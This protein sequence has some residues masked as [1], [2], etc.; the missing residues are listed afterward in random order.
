MTK[1]REFKALVRERMTKTGERYAAARAQLLSQSTAAS[2]TGSARDRFPG[3]LPGYDQFGGV[4]N[5]TAPV[6]NVLGFAGLR[7][8]ATGQPFTEAVV[9]GLCGGPGF[10]Y[11]VFEYKGWPPLLSIALQSRSMPDAFLGQGLARLGV[12]A[13][14]HETGSAVAARKTLE[15]VL[16]AGKPAPCATG[17]RTVAVVGQAGGPGA[18]WWVDGR[19]PVPT[20]LTAEML[21]RLRGGYKATKNRLT[22]LDGPDTAADPTARLREAVAQTAQAYLDPPVPKAFQGNCGFAGL[23]KWQRLLTDP[24]DAKGWRTLFAEGPRACAGLTRAYEWI[25]CFVAPGAGRPFYASFLDVAAEVLSAPA[26]RT[27]AGAFREAGA[28]WSSLADQ[29]ATTED[30][31]VRRVCDAADA[32]LEALDLEGDCRTAENPIDV[33]QKRRDASADSTLTKAAAE[34][35]Y[36]DMARQLGR[37]VKV[38][39]DAIGAMGGLGRPARAAAARPTRG[40]ST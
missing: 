7:W 39:R 21:A 12:K 31:A 22:T 18:D 25:A 29:I 24:K 26:L 23:E 40:R 27:A 33:I 4:Q 28:L 30:V 1:Q 13:T 32:D 6:A 3:L 17:L 37:I 19:A 8:G 36:A 38:E 10:L 5:G 34:A 2:T 14:R 11:A 16:G 20:R 9:N 35:I 15:A